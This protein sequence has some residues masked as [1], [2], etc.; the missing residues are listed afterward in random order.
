MK[1][2]VLT[3]STL[4]FTLTGCTTTHTMPFDGHIT[5]APMIAS[6]LKQALNKP[7][8]KDKKPLYHIH[9]EEKVSL[10]R[11]DPLDI[12]TLHTAYTLTD[13]VTLTWDPKP[14]DRTIKTVFE[15]STIL[16]IPQTQSIQTTPQVRHAKARLQKHIVGDIIAYLH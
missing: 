14:K 2:L 10:D 3:L 13:R 7:L 6:Q 11:L 15:Q 5:G 1:M 4:L 16:D 8:G 12:K 9:L